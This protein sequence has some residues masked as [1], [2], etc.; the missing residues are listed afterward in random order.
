MYDTSSWVIAAALLA[1]MLVAIE[2][3]Y[4]LGRRSQTSIDDP[5][6]AHINAVQAS[7]LGMLALLIGFTFSL[8]LQRFDSRS[9]AVV[10]EANAIGT[11]YLRADLL[12]DPERD[13]AKSL[14]R[15]YLDLRV[16]AGRETL[17]EAAQRL[18]LVQSSNRKLEE[19]WAVVVRALE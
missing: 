5:S 19:L 18:A 13:Q 11:A 4:R 2:T 15:D 1:S 17:A 16:I 3:G 14:I 8:A 12:G 7:M 10:A 6:V 9:E